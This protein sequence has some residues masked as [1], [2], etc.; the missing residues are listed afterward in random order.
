MKVLVDIDLIFQFNFM[1][2]GIARKKQFFF[3]SQLDLIAKNVTEALNELAGIDSLHLDEKKV[4]KT[5]RFRPEGF[6]LFQKYVETGIDVLSN[7]ENELFDLILEG[8]GIEEQKNA[9]KLVRYQDVSSGYQKVL[10]ANERVNKY[11]QERGIST[12][13]VDSQNLDFDYLFENVP[14]NGAFEL[15]EKILIQGIICTGFGRGSREIGFPTA[16][17]DF[18]GKMDILPGV[19]AGIVEFNGNRYK[20]AVNVGWCPFYENKDL[21]YE[22]YILNEFRES[23]VGMFLRCELSFYLRSEASFRKIDDLIQAIRLDVAL[24]DQLIHI[25]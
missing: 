23:L 22:V 5:V 6:T 2:L 20:G 12:V 4:F 16:N 3:N 21:S 11:L 14:W 9:L 19:Y 18:S 25:E 8:N 7:V 13:F 15:T 10:T 17:V 1:V 24:C